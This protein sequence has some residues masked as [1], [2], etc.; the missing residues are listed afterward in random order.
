MQKEEVQEL[1]DNF[2]MKNSENFER[3]SKENTE[4]YDALIGAVNFISLK[5]GTQGEETL[6]EPIVP[7]PQPEILSIVE[8][9]PVVVE[10]TPEI[11]ETEESLSEEDLKSAIKSL[12]PLAAYDDELKEELKRLTDELKA[13]KKKK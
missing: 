7:E 10:E 3:V 2:V 4:L 9:A 5:Y 11:V 6:V 1:I 12:K 13:L 8:E